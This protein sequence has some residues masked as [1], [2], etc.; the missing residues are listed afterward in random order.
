MTSQTTPA[1]TPATTAP[2][3]HLEKAMA[4]VQK[5]NAKVDRLLEPLQRE[6]RIMKWPAEYQAILWEA[7]M[8]EA[9]LRGEKCSE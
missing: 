7:V 1:T 9:K 6:M 5:I 8:M 2:V 3:A 4:M